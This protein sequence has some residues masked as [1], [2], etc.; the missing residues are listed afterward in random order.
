VEGITS[1]LTCSAC[2]SLMAILIKDPVVDKE[3][4]GSVFKQVCIDFKIL[5]ER[6][7]DAVIDQY[8]VKNFF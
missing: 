1:A 3:M 7:C 2:T 4:L 8:L 5:T 6:V